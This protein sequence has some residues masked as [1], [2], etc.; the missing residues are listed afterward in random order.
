MLYKIVTLEV[1]SHPACLSLILLV[2]GQVYDVTLGVSMETPPLI[3]HACMRL[4]WQSSYVAVALVV[5][6]ADG[7]TDN[8]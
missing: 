2:E 3:N 6:L 5:V 7:P 1:A 8:S 4:I